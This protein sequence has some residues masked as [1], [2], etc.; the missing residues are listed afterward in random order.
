MKKTTIDLD[1]IAAPC[2]RCLEFAYLGKMRPECI[3]EL[4]R[5][6]LAPLD[7][8]TNKPTCRDCAAAWALMRCTPALDWE[9]ARVAVANDRQEQYRLPGV[10]M[11]LVQ[12]GITQPNKA[13]DF[14]KHLE[15]LKYYNWFG[16]K[17]DHAG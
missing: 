9:M 16:L 6:A 15:W 10:I 4:P 5:G 17:E 13:G 11:G 7:R 3:Q 2:S 14:K 1:D 8:K 12:A